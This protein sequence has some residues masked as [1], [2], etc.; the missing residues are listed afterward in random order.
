MTGG[1]EVR[2]GQ[3]ATVSTKLLESIVVRVA[4]GQ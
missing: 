2:L 1:D 3:G 4:L